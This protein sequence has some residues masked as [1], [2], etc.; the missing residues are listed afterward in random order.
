L[1][2]GDLASVSAGERTSIQSLLAQDWIVDH[3]LV[4]SGD[5][6]QGHVVILRAKDGW[7]LPP[8][9]LTSIDSHASGLK[10]HA[11]LYRHERGNRAKH[12]PRIETL[13]SEVERTLSQVATGAAPGHAAPG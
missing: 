10:L 13:I 6:V 7:F 12:L 11:A 4:K 5:E 1:P 8:D 3:T 2:G 9:A